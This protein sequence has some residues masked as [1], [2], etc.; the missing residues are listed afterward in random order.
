MQENK[1]EI[2]SKIENKISETDL[3]I[4]NLQTTMQESKT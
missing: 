3:K 2:N 1:T 4:E